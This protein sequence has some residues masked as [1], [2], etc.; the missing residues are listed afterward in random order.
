MGDTGSLAIGGAL[1]TVAI[2]LKAE[3]LLLLIGG[4]FAAEA[5]SV[6]LQ[7]GVYKWHKR[8]AG[9]GVRRRPPGLP[10]GAAA[11]PLREAGLGRD[12]GRDPV[13][14]PRPPLR[15]GR[16]RRPSRCAEDAGRPAARAWRASGREVAVVGLGKSGVAAAPAAARPRRSRSTHPTP[17]PGPRS[18]SGPRGSAG[19]APRSTSAATTSPGSRRAVAVVVAP[20]VPPDV[21]PLE[22]ARARGR[23]DPR[24]GGYRVPRAPRA[25]AASASPAPTGRRPRPR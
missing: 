3:F 12:H 5:I 13:L 25:R 14:H 9:E 21:P 7:T 24:R 22:A 16:A 20:G 1:G 15:A 11:P 17:A 18:T 2:L 4:V 19:P 8:T 6:L 10:D 23:P